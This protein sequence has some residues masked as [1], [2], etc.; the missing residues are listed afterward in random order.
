MQNLSYPRIMLD[1]LEEP[2]NS[3]EQEAYDLVSKRDNRL[4]KGKDEDM[5]ISSVERNSSS[6]TFLLLKS[7]ICKYV[8]QNALNIIYYLCFIS[9]SC[10]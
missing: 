1:G 10:S 7:G 5:K 6:C 8:I 4:V 2:T 9:F 3:L